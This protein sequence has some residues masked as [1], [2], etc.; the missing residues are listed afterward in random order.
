MNGTVTYGILERMFQR[1]FDKAN[2][3]SAALGLKKPALNTL[4]PSGNYM[5][6][7]L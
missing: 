5:H 4:K 2:P 3:V 6:H 7:L 1:H